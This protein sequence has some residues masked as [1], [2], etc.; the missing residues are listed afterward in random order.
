LLLISPKVYS[1]G[2]GMKKR[3]TRVTKEL[4]QQMQNESKIKAK[5][6]VVIPGPWTN[7]QTSIEIVP[8]IRT[9]QG[10]VYSMLGAYTDDQLWKEKGW[11][12][13]V[14]NITSKDIFEV[15]SKNGADQYIAAWEKA[16][17]SEDYK[18]LYGTIV[19]LQASID[20]SLDPNV[21]HRFISCKAKT[22]RK[23]IKGFTAIRKQ[24]YVLLD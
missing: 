13:I 4:R 21:S 18:K 16:I 6:N 7:L 22:N 11:Y 17:N 19:I 2:K 9:T 24:K 20:H 10:I 1:K 15:V 5:K 8:E 12:P 14:I 3:K 23:S